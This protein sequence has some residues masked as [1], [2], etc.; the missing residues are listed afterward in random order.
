MFKLYR[1]SVSA[2]ALQRPS[3]PLERED[4]EDD[5]TEAETEDMTDVV[6]RAREVGLLGRAPLE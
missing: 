2:F 4:A 6:S 1:I 5:E 3:L